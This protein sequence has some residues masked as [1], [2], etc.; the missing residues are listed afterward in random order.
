MEITANALQTVNAGQNILFTD[1]P[2]SGTKCMYHRAG[3]GLITL[4]GITNQCYATF[5]VE[6]SGN[7]AVPT[8][9]TVGQ[10]SVA[11]AID[12]EPVGTTTMQATP[13]A[14]T[15]FWNV[16]SPVFV[17]VPRGCC[18]T[19]SVENTSTIPISVQNANLVVERTA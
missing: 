1:A 8:G 15:E 11:I 18:V 2:I 6:F 17:K 10:I 7:I 16:S 9:E 4:R 14:V 12:G 5:K 3:S 19:I 13:A